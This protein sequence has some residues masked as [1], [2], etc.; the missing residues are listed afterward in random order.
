MG[1]HPLI[2]GGHN[3]MDWRVNEIKLNVSDAAQ[4]VPDSVR[5][6]QAPQVQVVKTQLA[7]GV[8]L[9]GMCRCRAIA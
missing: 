1:D 7:P 8:V 2:P 9:M 5:N 6:A 4:A 3:W